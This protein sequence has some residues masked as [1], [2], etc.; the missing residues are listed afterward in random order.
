MRATLPWVLGLGTLLLGAAAH[1]DDARAASPH[2]AVTL[3]NERTQ[4]VL[5]TWTG[6]GN[7]AQ[8]YTAS[9]V[10][11]AVYDATIFDGGMGGTDE[12]L[13]CVGDDDD[14]GPSVGS[15]LS[16]CS[17]DGTSYL[18]FVR[19]ADQTFNNNFGTGPFTIAVSNGA[20][21]NT[22][23]GG[24]CDVVGA[25]MGD[26]L[27]AE[28]C[29]VDSNANCSGALTSPAEPRSARTTSAMRATACKV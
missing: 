16:F 12:S 15:T 9:L 27:E 3:W 7:A 28:A 4:P 10:Q 22:P 5:A 14:S 11:I 29:G 25:E 21:C 20:S 26:I 17:G 24:N 23:D 18:I 19:P 2:N 13:I 1:V 6:R 8:A